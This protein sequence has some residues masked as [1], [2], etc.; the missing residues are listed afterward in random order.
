MSLADW[1]LPRSSP[2]GFARRMIA[3]LRRRG[4]A[5]EITYDPETFRLTFD[6]GNLNLANAYNDY[7]AAPRG[8]RAQV[9]EAYASLASETKEDVGT[10]DEAR[11]HLLPKVRERFYHEAL[12]LNLQL[13]GPSP[14]SI[15]T[16]VVADELTVELVYD[17]PHSVSTISEKQLSEW[18][19]AFDEALTV[20]RD[21]LWR[22]SNEDFERVLPGLHVSRW[23]DTHDASRLFLHGLVWQLPVNGQHVAMVPN[24]NV[25]MVAGSDDPA[26]LVA[27]AELALTVLE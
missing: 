24:R 27:M 18:G 20:A 11:P 9:F 15:P 5:G 3:T 14:D 13:G 22:I 4:H 12:A 1:L 25:L 2:D 17:R 10:L 16:R 7:R 21:N 26:A 6:G 19:I 8:Q 23:H